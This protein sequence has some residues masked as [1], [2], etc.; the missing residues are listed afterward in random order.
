MQKAQ[1]FILKVTKMQTEKRE[2]KKKEEDPFGKTGEA[3]QIVIPRTMPF[4]KEEGE[5]IRLEIRKVEFKDERNKEEREEL[6][7]ARQFLKQ[8]KLRKLRKMKKS[9]GRVE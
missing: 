3:K 4:G 2:R 1:S 5:A 8:I 7:K 6:E 9:K